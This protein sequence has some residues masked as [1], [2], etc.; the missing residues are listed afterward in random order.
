MADWGPVDCGVGHSCCCGKESSGQRLYL[1]YDD[2]DLRC[3]RSRGMTL[4]VH[5][6]EL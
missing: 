4:P 5:Q 2:H 6:V 1:W 3:V